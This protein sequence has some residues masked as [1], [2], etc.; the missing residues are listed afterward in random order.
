[1]IKNAVQ[2]QEEIVLSIA[3]VKLNTMIRY[4]FSEQYRILNRSTYRKRDFHLGNF[5]FKKQSKKVFIVVVDFYL[6][7]FVSELQNQKLH[8][9]KQRRKNTSH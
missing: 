3:V 7:I 9:K 2:H 8:G 6:F 1:M 5:I 4:M